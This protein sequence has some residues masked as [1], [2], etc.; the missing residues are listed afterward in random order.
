MLIYIVVLMAMIAT[1]LYVT[2][3]ADPLTINKSIDYSINSQITN[4]V[5][6]YAIDKYFFE[7]KWQ[8]LKAWRYSLWYYVDSS[9]NELNDTIKMKFLWNARMSDMIYN[10]LWESHD[11]YGWFSRFVNWEDDWH[12]YAILVSEI[13][14][15]WTWDWTWNDNVSWFKV[16]VWDVKQRADWEYRFETKYTFYK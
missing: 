10:Q 15:D 12:S 1:W 2:I 16:E 9:N 8:W 14:F 5:L 3:D 11:D 7:T 4:N 13:S 6:D